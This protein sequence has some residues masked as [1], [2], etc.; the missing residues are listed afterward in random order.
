MWVR[1]PRVTRDRRGRSL[2]CIA[3]RA[4][5][6]TKGPSH[7]CNGR[8]RSRLSAALLGAS[9]HARKPPT[10]KLGEGIGKEEDLVAA[11]GC[12]VYRRVASCQERR[13][14]SVRKTG[15]SDAAAPACAGSVNSTQA[16]S[17]SEA[18][19]HPASRR[20][21]SVHATPDRHREHTGR[22]CRQRRQR[23]WRKRDLTAVAKRQ[24][25]PPKSAVAT[26]G[27]PHMPP[28]ATHSPE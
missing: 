12:A 24:R 1:T 15:R 21:H 20:R 26:G 22:R 17:R 3:G 11:H 9:S 2:P 5:R 25:R 13:R 4:H 27:W 10:Q 19:R 18:R 16:D 6:K 28:A 8:G 14:R 7:R 23:R